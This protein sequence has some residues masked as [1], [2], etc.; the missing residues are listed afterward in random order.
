MKA[1][2]LVPV[3][4]LSA[5]PFNQTFDRATQAYQAGDYAEAIRGYEQLVGEDVVDA[6]VFYNLGNAYFRSGRLG[7]AI[8]NYER[9][10]HLEPRHERARHNL[11]QCVQQTERRLRAPQGPRW[12]QSLLFWH[13]ALS[14][15]VVKRLA[16]V[17]WLAM[18]TCLGVRQWRRIRYTGRI[19][20]LAGVLSVLFGASV[21]VK[22]HPQPL[23]VASE[24]RVPVR[25]GTDDSQQV[26]F[27]LYEG[28]RV[29]VD[30]QSDGWVRVATSDGKRGW[31][32]EGS[33]TLVGP[34][35]SRAPEAPAESNRPEVRG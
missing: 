35:Y 2:W 30:G 34:P 6:D 11:E 21:W 12:E 26:Y 32:R 7:P 22:A 5:N 13:G 27:E 1:W 4:M 19:A 3:W 31:A 29:A 8:A 28:D 14:I 20:V 24:E 15:R 16:V 10:L 25:Y 9:A 18:W 33:F 23:A 17:S